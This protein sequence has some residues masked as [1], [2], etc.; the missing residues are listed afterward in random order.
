MTSCASPALMARAP[1]PIASRLEPHRR[2]TVLRRHV[3]RQA[4][5]QRRHAADVA[6]VLAGLV[7]AAVEQVVDG[8]PIDAGIAFASAP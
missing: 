6:V 3:D 1:M 2:L 7:G 5:Q 8:G 4:G